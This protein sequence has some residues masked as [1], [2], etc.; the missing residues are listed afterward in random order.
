[1]NYDRIAV[2]CGRSA[3]QRLSLHY[4]GYG[5]RR[6]SESYEISFDKW[7]TKAARALCE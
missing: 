5:T 6:R 2:I 3:V 4:I 1:M 7:K